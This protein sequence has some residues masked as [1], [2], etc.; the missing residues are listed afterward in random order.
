MKEILRKFGFMALAVCLLVAGCEKDGKNDWLYSEGGNFEPVSHVTGES[1]YGYAL[2]RWNLPESLNALTMIDISWTNTEQ[3]TASR[4]LTHF[5]DSLWLE[6]EKNEYMFRIKSCGIAGEIVVDSILLQVSDWRSEPVEIIQNVIYSVI[7]NGV[8]LRWQPNTNRAFAKTTFNL[9][10]AADVLQ[11]TIIR[12]K[13]ES[14]TAQ[15]ENL[16]YNTDYILRYYSENLAGMSTDTVE[17]AFKTERNAPDMPLIEVDDDRRGNDTNGNKIAGVY[18]YSADIKWSQPDA[19]MDSLR[20]TFTGLN[21]MQY[22]FR[23]KAQDRIG[24]LTFLPGGSVAVSVS[25]KMTGDDEWSGS[26]AQ[27]LT[28]KQPQDLYQFRLDNGPAGSDH[29][30][31]IGQGWAAQASLTGW[32]AD[33][34][35]KYTYEELYKSVAVKKT[36]EIRLKP[37]FLDE[38]EMCPAIE[39]LQVGYDNSDPSAAQVPV[40]SEF[41]NLVKHLKNLRLIKIRP[42]YNGRAMLLD[43]FTKAK[44]PNL[45]VEDLSGNDIQK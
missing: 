37:K 32:Q 17:Y 21:D 29:Q 7:G 36:F 10:S 15:F 9:Y 22:D 31:K 27:V 16:E 6:L 25:A 3:V 2:L 39:V 1:G 19:G 38:I 28:T 35:K 41:V 33:G 43:E 45:R 24:Y 34:K 30:S 40:L 14:V 44:Y 42:A 26:K 8:Y 11:N 12:T 4:K 13:G 23:F 20:V 5:E 18:A